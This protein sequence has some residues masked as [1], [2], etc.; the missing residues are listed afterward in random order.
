[1]YAHSHFN[2]IIVC[3]KVGYEPDHRAQQVYIRW[4]MMVSLMRFWGTL[5]SSRVQH[6]RDE[7]TMVPIDGIPNRPFYF[8]QKDIIDGPNVKE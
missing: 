3:L 6:Q 4:N 5:F 1:M 2:M 7:N 8:Y